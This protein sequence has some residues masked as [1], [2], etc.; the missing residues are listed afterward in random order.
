M[1]IRCSHRPARPCPP[2]GCVPSSGG[3]GEELQ[4]D[5]IGVAER[6]SGPIVGVHDA[7]VG[8]A[9][10]VQTVRPRASS[11][12][13]A[14]PKDTWSRPVWYS[15]NLSPVA[16]GWV[17]RP[18]SWPPPIR[19]TVWWKPPSSR[20][21]QGPAPSRRAGCTTACCARGQSRSRRH[22][23]KREKQSDEPPG[24]MS[25]TARRA[26]CL[27]R[28][29]EPKVARSGPVASGRV[30]ICCQRRMGRTVDMAVPGATIPHG[31]ACDDA[32][33]GSHRSWSAR[34]AGGI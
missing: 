9:E 33:S 20:P 2:R 4:R 31:R 21:R 23:S 26:F 12:R 15:E 24:V 14:Q 3:R 29:P 10:L 16:R 17:C 27:P 1:P 22:G 28:V 30:T 32:R 5:A 6:D 13:S 18:K 7:S 8:D 11:S 19:Y 34:L 25:R